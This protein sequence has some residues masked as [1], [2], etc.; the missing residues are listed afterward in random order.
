MKNIVKTVDRK[1]VKYYEKSNEYEMTYARP[2]I[3]D[4]FG[5]YSY[6]YTEC[7]NWWYFVNTNPM[8]RD[9]CIC[10]KCGKTV[11]VVVPK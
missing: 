10:P 11:R 7:G 1:R 4:D 3:S 2:R 9:G 6:L 5:E 8:R